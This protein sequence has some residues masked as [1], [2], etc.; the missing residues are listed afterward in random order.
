MIFYHILFRNIVHC[1]VYSHS[2]ALS[3]ARLTARGDAHGAIFKG[4]FPNKHRSG[5]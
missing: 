5:I 4:P 3:V 1:T 2:I